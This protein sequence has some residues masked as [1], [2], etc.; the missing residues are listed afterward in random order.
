[1]ITVVAISSSSCETDVHTG[2]QF[3][4]G[5][6]RW[7]RR[8]VNHTGVEAVHHRRAVSER[9]PLKAGDSCE[10]RGCLVMAA[11]DRDGW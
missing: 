10:D 2:P 5:P 8:L 4:V 3:T 7:R 9:G 6:C 11:D 1:M